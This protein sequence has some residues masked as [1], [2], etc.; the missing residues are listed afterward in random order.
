MKRVLTAVVL[1]PV[2]LLLAF[3]APLW[4][5]ALAVA[6]I[7]MLALH[8]YLNLTAH[9][10]IKPV[11][12][13]A[14]VLSLVIVWMAFAVPPSVL[15]PLLYAV[16]GLLLLLPIIFGIPIVFRSELKMA[17]AA[18]SASA[19]G[20]LY[21]AGSL[22]L[23]VLFRADPLRCVLVIFTLFAVWA[24]DIA[25]YYVGK[26]LGRHKLAPA[27]SPNKT[28]EGAIA[29]VAASVIVAVLVLHFH[30]QI[31][32]LF[33]DESLGLT[34]SPAFFSPNSFWVHGIILGTLSNVAAQFGDLFESALKRGA[35]VKDSGGILP[36]HGGVLD[37]IDAL[38]FAIPVVWY[39]ATFSGLLGQNIIFRIHPISQ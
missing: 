30:E 36:G 20:I 13:P 11:R 37:R 14:Y 7:V 26:N 10:G 15:A 6:G 3:R 31:G 12:W 27:V 5:F 23:L 25:A 18:P 39:Y 2:V 38:L 35:Q 17:L 28:W 8:E 9:Y 34:P 33:A 29:S 1:I 22:S 16:W 21:V 24:G 19:F 4:L 32:L